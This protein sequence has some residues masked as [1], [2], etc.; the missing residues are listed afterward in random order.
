MARIEKTITIDFEGR[1]KGKQFFLTEMPAPRAE[2]WAIRA[3]MAV[4]SASPEIPPGALE[5]G[6]GVIALLGLHSVLRA[7]YDMVKPLLDEMMT[8]VQIV[9]PEM[10]RALVIGDIEEVR[11]MTYLRDEVF[12]LH[13]NFS[14]IDELLPISEALGSR[15]EKSTS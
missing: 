15:T 9:M 1:D 10:T 5:A 11:T 6:W 14:F 4:S 8:C 7:P 13:A 3:M 12:R 2:D